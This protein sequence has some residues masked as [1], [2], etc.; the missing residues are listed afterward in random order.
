M[1]ARDLR[2]RI[3]GASSGG[4]LMLTLCPPTLSV[5]VFGLIVG[6]IF[7]SLLAAIGLGLLVLSNGL[8]W[9]LVGLFLLPSGFLI[10][11][12][13]RGWLLFCDP[14]GLWRLFGSVLTNGPAFP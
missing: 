6:A 5:Q 1:R 8:R 13:F 2:R 7:G 3:P 4:G 12:T 10:G 11:L 9:R 14:W